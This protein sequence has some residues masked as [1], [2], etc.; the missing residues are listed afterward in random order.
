MEVDLPNDLNH[1]LFHLPLLLRQEVSE[2]KEEVDATYF[3]EVVL[4]NY[5]WIDLV[6]AVLLVI[7]HYVK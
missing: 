2:Y 3:F 6:S 7:A 4:A 5:G 1:D